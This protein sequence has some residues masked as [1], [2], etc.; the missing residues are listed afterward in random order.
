MRHTTPIIVICAAFSL[1]CLPGCEDPSVARYAQADAKLKAAAESIASAARRSSVDRVAAAQ[2]LRQAANEA[3]GLSGAT[4]AQQQAAQALVATARTQ[5]ALLELGHANRLESASRAERGLAQG[6]LSVATQL[7]WV[8]DAHSQDA[9]AASNGP[10]NAQRSDA[11]AQ[12]R[13]LEEATRLLGAQVAQLRSDNETALQEAQAILADA[14][15]TRQRGLGAGRGEITVLAVQAGEQRD[16]ARELQSKAA[17]GEVELVDQESILRLQSSATESARRKAAALESAVNALNELGANFQ[18]MNV[19]ANE[20][21]SNLRESIEKIAASTDPQK[22]AGLT[23]CFERIT[24]DLDAAQSAAGAGSRSAAV[25]IAAAQARA[26]FARAEAHL[27]HAQMVYLLSKSACMS[28]QSRELAQQ[29]E[30]LLKSA[31]DLTKAAR[32][33]YTTAKDALA[34]SGDS[35]PASTALAATIDRAIETIKIPS[36]E[37]DA[38]QAP[39]AKPTKASAPPATDTPETDAATAPSGSA[40]PP[41]ARAADLAA[42]LG[43]SDKDPSVLEKFDTLFIAK[44]EAGITVAKTMYELPMALGKLQAAMIAKFGSADLGP[45]G[46]MMKAQQGRASVSEEADATALISIEGPM[47][48]QVINAAMTDDGWKI[49]ADAWVE[50]M[51]DTTRGQLSAAGG[52]MAGLTSAI[53]GVTEKISDGS[54]PSAQAA[55]MALMTALQAGMGGGAGNGP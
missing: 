21:I 2:E 40:G 54:I 51:D 8:S 7:Q 1:S 15:E 52:M 5:A 17:S 30:A 35:S 10:D 29:A 26:L 23:E 46:Q 19:Q 4:A 22:N 24:A 50:S 49:D 13:Q 38:S 25:N 42:F 11:A 34:N 16:Q 39:V 45:L 14:E 3:S 31:Q 47:G 41:F 33:A 53:D 55:Q 6:L 9:L 27:Q 43:S 48:T 20:L 28:E 44:T 18:A 12:S 32:D 36:L 37:F